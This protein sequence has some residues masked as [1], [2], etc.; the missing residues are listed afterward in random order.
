LWVTLN[1]SPLAFIVF[2]LAGWI[3]HQEL[4]VIEYLKA[5]NRMLREVPE[6]GLEAV[7]VAV[8]LVLESAVVRAEHVLNVVARL[9]PSA[10]PEWIEPRRCQGRGT[11]EGRWVSVDHLVNAGQDRYGISTLIGSLRI[12]R[13]TSASRTLGMIVEQSGSSDF[14]GELVATITIARRLR[15]RF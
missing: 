7:L 5:E 13:R 15:R 4:I 12:V 14:A 11:R 2:L 9:K 1:P 8:E 3:S 6:S 10:Q